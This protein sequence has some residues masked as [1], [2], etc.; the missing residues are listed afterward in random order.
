MKTNIISVGETRS[1]KTLGD[2]QIYL[3]AND[4]TNHKYDVQMNEEFELTRT[5]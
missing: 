5:Q 4:V 3:E 2:M 1:F